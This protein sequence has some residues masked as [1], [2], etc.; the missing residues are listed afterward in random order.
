MPKTP[1]PPFIPG[2]TLSASF[3]HKAAKPVLDQH[4]P[5]LAYSA[6]S[7][8]FCSDVMG[9]DTEISRD[10]CWGPRFTL[11]LSEDDLSSQ[12]ETISKALAQH[13][14]FEIDGYPTNF[15]KPDYEG[16]VPQWTDKR[17]ILHSISLAT[18]SGFSNSYLRI[19]ATREIEEDAWFALPPQHLF[20]IRSGSV[21]HDG[22]GLLNPLRERLHW[23]PRDVW[24][25]LMGNQWHALNEEEPFV[26][27]AGHVG[28]E[29]GSRLIASSQIREMMKLAFLME[30]Q[31]AP[32]S[33]WFGT[34]FSRLRCS[35]KLT[36]LFHEA[37]DAQDWKTREASLNK[38]YLTLGEMHNALGVTEPLELGNM[39]IA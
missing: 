20:T 2:L 25:F 5:S 31:Y 16:G 10:H 30:K 7:I 11:F 23:Y 35:A 17:P 28:D 4:F 15:N 34:A 12:G 3:F 14:P 13:L 32:Y 6:G 24:L 19:D 26:G 8:G 38:A 39:A 21:F 22:L 27:R 37:M 33:K 1:L 18:V 9:F 29:L 36:P